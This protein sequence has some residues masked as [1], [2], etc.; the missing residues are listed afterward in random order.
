[1][2]GENELIDAVMRLRGA[3]PDAW[4]HFVLTMRRLAAIKAAELVRANYESVYQM[5]GQA[6]AYEEIASMLV[7]APRKAAKAEELRNGRATSS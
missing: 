2:T 5:Q 4:E 7:E 6:R 1:V 3:A